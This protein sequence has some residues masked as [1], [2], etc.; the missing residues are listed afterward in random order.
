MRPPLRPSR[1]DLNSQLSLESLLIGL[2]SPPPSWLKLCPQGVRAPG[3]VDSGR[4]PVARSFRPCLHLPLSLP[5]VSPSFLPWRL[6]AS[7]SGPLG[8]YPHPGGTPPSSCPPPESPLFPL[9]ASGTPLLLL[10]G[11]ITTPRGIQTGSSPPVPTPAR[12]LTPSPWQPCPTTWPRSL[13]PA[14]LWSS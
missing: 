6:Y 1:R 11:R 8:G 9:P 5:S 12:D 3:S 13:R 2:G 10:L 7:P 14:R 4:A